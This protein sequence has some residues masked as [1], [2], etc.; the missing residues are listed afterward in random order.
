M[1]IKPELPT[2]P[3]WKPERTVLVLA[4][5]V[6]FLLIGSAI[7]YSETSAVVP[8]A[9]PAKLVSE[10]IV[11]EDLVF[12]D[13]DVG[14]KKGKQ[15]PP[16][17]VRLAATQTAKQLE[18]GSRLFKENCVSC[19]GSAG[20]GDGPAGQSLQPRPRDL[21]QLGGWKQGTR[22]SDG[23][24]TVTLGL[25]GT[26]MPAFDYLRHEQRFAIAHF[27]L[28]L[29]AGHPADT[30]ASLAALDKDF[31]LSQGSREPSIIPV[32]A[33]VDRVLAEESSRPTAQEAAIEDPAAES[34]IRSVMEDDGEA[35]LY[36]LLSADDS[37]RLDAGRLKTLGCMD[38]AAAGLKPRV[39]RLA[40][41]EWQTL[42]V[43]LQNRYAAPGA[44]TEPRA[45]N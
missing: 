37:W 42:H 27:V 11:P 24:R 18:E 30:D 38:P 31:S 29:A 34:L 41:A 23:F 6:Q 36:R 43:Y 45:T 14:A 21:T 32:S 3:R 16:V 4:V 19:H 10:I 5:V 25:T 13:T 26:K 40:D 39:R 12:A 1:E 22:L 28:S 33:A 2:D 35:R 15:L 17:D 9:T 7:W 20:R 8:P 44:V